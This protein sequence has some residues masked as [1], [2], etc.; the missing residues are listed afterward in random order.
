MTTKDGERVSSEPDVLVR[1]LPATSSTSDVPGEANTTTVTAPATSESGAKPDPAADAAKADA[2]KAASDKAAADAAAAKAAEGTKDGETTP[3]KKKSAIEQR[4]SDVT[5]DKKAALAKAAEEETK[6]VAA[7]AKADKLATDLASVLERVDKVLPK[8]P[9]DVKPTRD[10]FDDPNKYDEAL[11]AWSA[12][13]ASQKAKAE[14]EANFAKQREDEAKKTDAD[15][16]KAESDRLAA[17]WNTKVTEA[18]KDMVDFDEVILNDDVQ[19]TPTM[20][21]AI[22]NSDIGPKIAYHLGK[23]P[24][25]AARIA[26]LAPAKQLLALGALEHVLSQPPKTTTTPDPIKPVKGGTQSASEKP[27]AE[28]SMEEYSAKRM[29]ELH[30]KRATR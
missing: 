29:A 9:E 25:E 15:R 10:K 16:Q 21:G 19:I 20:G 30:P 14:A 7:E 6:R 24:D 26:A 18:K 1:T 28:M 17:D 4:F 22:L 23:N 8:A 27:V 13:A 12:R 11:V 2:A 5:A 3:P